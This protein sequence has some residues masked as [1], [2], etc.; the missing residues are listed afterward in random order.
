MAGCTFV[1]GEV[2]VIN[3][4]REELELVA[5]HA[6]SIELVF[7]QVEFALALT[8]FQIDQLVELH[9]A[10][11]PQH[12]IASLL[13]RCYLFHE[14]RAGNFPGVALLAENEIAGS[15]IS[16]TEAGA[17]KL[18]NYINQVAEHGQQLLLLE[19]QFSAPP[20]LDQLIQISH[21]RLLHYLQVPLPKG[22]SVRFDLLVLHD[23]ILEDLLK[24]K[25]LLSAPEKSLG[26]VASF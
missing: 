19:P 5:N 21:H 8:Y 13:L 26:A 6:Q 14:V 11:T 12:G 7:H 25:V 10:V 18:L 16:Q 17:V 23:C 24:E 3:F 20:D 22:A 9:L 15:Q 1:R 4:F 2:L